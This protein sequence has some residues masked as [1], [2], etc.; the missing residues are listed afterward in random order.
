[1]SN[2]KLTFTKINSPD[3]VLAPEGVTLT[4]IDKPGTLRSAGDTG[5]SI[6]RG[7]ATGTK[8][9]ADAFGADNVVSRGASRIAD[10]LGGMR[11]DKSKF[12]DTV[13]TQR[14]GAAEASGSKWNEF[15]A[16]VRNFADRPIDMLAEGIGSSAPT[17]AAAALTGGVV[18]P[19]TATALRIAAGAGMGSV[20]GA[21]AVKGQ[22]YDDV[23]ARHIKAGLSEADAGARA[24]EAQSYSGENVDQIALGAGLGA[25]AGTTGAE[26]AV[27]RIIGHTGKTGIKPVIANMAAEGGTEFAQG[28]QERLAS[29]IAAQREGFDAPT[30][31]GVVGQGTVEGLAG[32][33][34]GAAFGVAEQMAGRP[35]VV[36]DP[37][38]GA[39]SKALSLHP[40]VEQPIEQPIAEPIDPAT[41]GQANYSKVVAQSAPMPLDK[42][43]SIAD[44][45]NADGTGV[46]TVAPH[47]SMGFT[48]VPSDWMTDEQLSS[49]ASIQGDGGRLEAPAEPDQAPIRVDA[50]GNAIQETP[51][52]AAEIAA[53]KQRYIDMGKPTP[54]GANPNDTIQKAAELSIAAGIQPQ[55]TEPGADNGRADQVPVPEVAAQSLESGGNQLPGSEFVAPDQP[56]GGMGSASGVTGIAVPSSGTDGLAGSLGLADT[57]IA[58]SSDIAG[59]KIDKKWTAFDPASGTLGINRAE[60]PQIKAE[61]RGAMVN[62][63]NARGIPHQQETVSAGDLKPTQAEF[64]PSKVKQAMGFEGGDRSILV[65][66]DNHV[67][68]GHHQWLA[69]REAGEPVK[70]IRLNA[71]IRELL[72]AAAEFPSSHT[73]AGATATGAVADNARA[74]NPVVV[75]ETPVDAPQTVIAR[76]GTTPNSAD[77]VTVRSGVVHIGEY[78]AQDFESGKDITVPEGSTFEQVADALRKGNVLSTKQRIYMG[79]KGM[80]QAKAKAPDKQETSDQD[81]PDNRPLVAEMDADTLRRELLTDALTGLGNRRAYDESAKLPVQAV[82]DADGLKWV[83]DNLGHD[84]GDKLLKAIGQALGDETQNAYH[85]SGDEFIVQAETEAEV[86]AIMDRAVA[87]MDGVRIDGTDTDGKDI[88]LTGVG[89]SYG[90]A[91]DLREAEKQLGQHKSERETQGQRAGRGEI[92]PNAAIGSARGEDQ[93]GDAAA[94][95]EQVAREQDDVAVKHAAIDA[96]LAENREALKG[97]KVG[98][99]VEFTQPGTYT[100]RDG[101]KR[102]GLVV[103]GKIE[104]IDDA[105]QGRVKVGNHS[106]GAQFLKK[107]DGVQPADTGRQDGWRGN[108]IKASKVMKD[109]GIERAD[110]MKLA[111]MLAAIDAHDSASSAKQKAP[112]KPRKPKVSPL[113]TKDPGEYGEAARRVFLQTIRKSGGVSIDDA[114]DI[115]GETVAN[116]YRLSPGFFA[117]GAPGIDLVARRLHEAGYITD[118]EY[119]DTDGGVQV[120]RDLINDALRKAPVLTS[121]QQERMAELEALEADAHAELQDQD[122]QDMLAEILGAE[123]TDAEFAGL[124]DGILPDDE[125]NQMDAARARQQEQDDEQSGRIEDQAGET[126]P[127]SAEARAQGG[128]GQPQ[129]A[130]GFDLAGQTPAELAAAD[131]Q[132]K[133]E[134]DKAERE[135]NQATGPNVTADQVDLF[136]TQEGLFNSN[137]D[138]AKEADK[139]IQAYTPP[140]STKEA[141]ARWE[142]G[143]ERGANQNALFAAVSKALDAGLFYNRD[144]DAFVAKEL[145]VTD[146]QRKVGADKVEGGAFG[147]DIYHARKAV[148]KARADKSNS[149]AGKRLGLKVGEN[150]GKLRLQDGK[151]ASAATVEAVSEKDVTLIAKRGPQTIRVTI[152]YTS[153]ETYAERAENSYLNDKQVTPAERLAQAGQVD[154]GLFAKPV[155]EPPVSM[156]REQPVEMN[157]PEAAPDRDSFTLDRLNRDTDQIESVTFERGEYVRYTLS[158]KDSFGEIDGISHARSEFSVDGLWYPFGFAYKA[159]K[160][161]AAEKPTV[162]LSSVIESA[163]KKYG[164]DLGYADRIH[165][166]AVQKDLFDRLYKGEA[167]ADEFK[168]AF[169]S[170]QNNKAG[171]TAELSAMTKDGLFKEFPGLAYRY[172]NDKKAD[173]VEA[174]YRGMVTQFVLGDSLTYGMGKNAMENAVRAIVDKTTDADLAKFADGIKQSIAERKARKEEAKAGMDNPETLEDF[175]RLLHARRE[176]MGGATFVELRMSLTPEQRAQYDIL[177]AEKSR[178][179]RG[180]KRD[181]ERTRVQAAD[182][183]TGAEIIATKHTRDGYDLFVVKAAERVERDVYNQWLSAAKKMGGWYSAFKGNGAIPGFQFKTREGAE[184]FQKY[185]SAGDTQAVQEQAKA[186]RNEFADDRSQTAVERLTEMADSLE[187][188]A[189]ASLGQ[190]RKANTDKRARQAASA[191][192]AANSDKAMAQTM[193]NI[194]GAIENGTAKMLD[195]VRQKVQVETL[196]GFVN[197]AQSDKLR[198][199]YPAYV[200]YERH[201]GE[202]PTADTADYVTFPNYTAFRSDLASLGR[203]LLDTEGTK[204]LG[205][206]LMKVADDVSDAYLKFAKENIDKVSRFRTKDGGL[207]AFPSKA[208]AEASIQ[209]SGYKGAA[210][211]LPVKRNENV[212]ILSPSEAIKRGVWTGDNDK[213][214]TLN[215]EFGAELVEKIGKASRRGEKVSVPWQFESAYDKRK[216]LAAMGIETPAE[217]RAAVREFI[218]LRETPKEADKIKEMERAMIGRRNDGMDFFPTPASVADEMVE[219]AD[220]QPGMSVLEPSAGMGHIAERIRA[221]GVDPDVVELSNERNEL[222][223]A[224]GFRVVG[225]DFMD[226]NPREFFTFGDTFRDKDGTEGVMRGLGGMGSN[227]VRLVVNGDERTARYV[228]RDSL[229]PVSKNGSDSGYDRILMNPPFGDRRDA[230]HVQHAYELLKPGGRIVAIMGEGVFFGSDK[231]AQA[232]RDWLEQ[233]GA[234]DEKLNE[235]T[236]LDPGLPVNTGTNAR[237][238]VIDKPGSEIV[239]VAEPDNNDT[240]F[241]RTVATT[242]DYDKRIDAL[243]SGKPANRVGAVV[244]DRSDMLDM[245]GMGNK[246]VR[247]VESKV[248][249]SS[250]NHG[251]TA[252]HWKKIPE[253]LDSPAA[254]FDSDTAPGRLV[255]IAPERVNGAPVRMIIEPDVNMDG[256]SIN[257]MVNAYDAH[258]R[259]P[260]RHW[261]ESGLTRYIDKAKSRQLLESSGLQLPG[262]M[263][264]MSQEANGSKRKI[265]TDRDLVKYRSEQGAAFSRTDGLTDAEAIKRV[266]RVQGVVNGIKANWKNAPEIIVVADMQDARVP[267]RVR[268][269]DAEM[270]SNGASGEPRGFI[271]GG[272]VYIVAGQHK[273]VADVVTTVAHETLGHAG[274]R[275]LYG[276]ALNP[277]LRQ[278]VNMRRAEVNAKVKEYGFDPESERDLMRAAEEVLANMAQTQPELGFVKRAIAAI[279]QWLRERGYVKTLSDN[280]IISN[281]I[282]P[283]R[284]YIERGGKPSSGIESLQAAYHRVFHGTPH[285]FKPE[286]GFPHGRFHLDYI[287]TGEGAQ[288]YG[289][290]IYFAESHG[291]AG[292]YRDMARR[293]YINYAG[294][295]RVKHAAGQLASGISEEDTRDGLQILGVDEQKHD[296]IIKEARALLA[297][298]GQLYNLDIPNSVLPNLLDWDKPLSEQ[299]A[300]VRAA[301]SQI[302]E[303]FLL[304]DDDRGVSIYKV[305]TD[306]LDT[307]QGRDTDD[308]RG[309]KVASE[310][311]AS[312]GIVG[313]R[314]L[315]GNS[316]NKALK[317]IKREFLAELPEDAEIGEV[318]DMI[319]TGVFSAKNEALLSAMKADDWLGF[320]YPSQAVSAA[321]SNDLQ[322]YDASPALLQ[323]VSSA[324]EGGTYNFVIW[325]QPTLDKV[326]MLERNGEKLDAIRAADAAFS[327]TN[328]TE[329]AAQDPDIMFSRT[330]ELHAAV[331]QRAADLLTTQ[332]TFNNWWHKSVGTQYHKAHIDADFRKA[333]NAVQSYLSGMSAFANSS[334]DLAD[335]LIP[336]LNSIRDLWNAKQP[337]Q[338]DIKAIS[339]PIFTGTLADEKVYGADELRDRFKLTPNQIDLYVQF[340]ASV[341][342]SLDDLGKTDILRY[343]GA[344]VA[345]MR[346]DVLDAPT[347]SRAALIV[348]KRLQE[349]GKEDEAKVVVDKGVRVADL[350][351]KGYAP[352]TRFGRYTL[353]VTEGDEQ[354]YFS[355]FESEA[356]ANAM[357]RQM[358][359]G[360]P[361]A[362]VTQ[363][364]LSAE[365]YKLFN[366]I[367]PDTLEL[368]AGAMGVENN[369]LVQDYIKL[370]KSNRSAMKRL[371]KR[372]GIAGFSEDVPRILA[373]FIT[374]NARQAASNVYGSQM[375]KAAE[376]IPKEKGDVK[377]E[378]I[379]MIDFAR[380]PTEDAAKM[381]GMLFVQ[382]IGGSVASAMVNL[383]QP[384]TMSYPYLHQFSKSAG[385]ELAKAMKLATVGGTLD[386][387]LKQALKRAEMDGVVSPQEIHQLQAE[388]VK[389]GAGVGALARMFGVKGGT[390]NKLDDLSK[391][392]LFAW[393]SLFSLAEQFNRRSTFIAAYNIAR[394]NKQAD[395]FAFAEK[396]VVETQGIYNRGNR[397]DW[398]RGA[399][400]ALIFTFKQYSISYMEFLKRLPPK[401]RAIA[402]AILV[403]AAGLQ[404]IPFADDLDDLIDTLAQQMGYAWNTKAEKEKFA[405]SILGQTGADF[406]L[407]GTSALPGFPLDFSARLGMSNL[408]PGTGMLLKNK[409]DK[410][411]EVLDVFGVAG[412]VVKDALRGDVLPIAVRNMLKAADMANTGM[413]R[414]YSGKKVIDT[415]GLDAATKLIGFHPANVAREGRAARMD[416]QDVQLAR[417]I[418]SEI[419]G[420]MAQGIFTGDKKA[421]TKAREKLA[422]WNAKNPDKPIVITSQQI[423]ARVK[424]MA[425]T[426]R[427]RLIKSAPKELR[428]GLVE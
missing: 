79:A 19:A 188:K 420:N 203:A 108:A 5:L 97:F 299:T 390:A 145:G 252:E 225:R 229:T 413:Y 323:A 371:I 141:S 354:L 184:A 161:S 269:M 293:D 349:L 21:G 154:D 313:N 89:V 66:S 167:S 363:G 223:E 378:A 405:A 134:A 64:S 220:I 326:A 311:L 416:M 30:W 59:D 174:A 67:L 279:R 422:D 415:N 227:R 370:A 408:L 290:G 55:I 194:A 84:S 175:N 209:H 15:K 294:P 18:N 236:F 381:R 204:K 224:K 160:P 49:F 425:Q 270:K 65:S 327:R 350:K 142:Y 116:S 88:V 60:M 50:Q 329:S 130:E 80:R 6:A 62:F 369:E 392:G 164:A 215:A 243:F 231:K 137:R 320:E 386:P 1:M 317:D 200:D 306:A 251:L 232:F 341:D 136:N 285:L 78:P 359:E 316:R 74:T 197:T 42:A 242:T 90:I 394:Q 346:A 39:I 423:M 217:L 256:L 360:N 72:T 129:R 24:Q 192:R 267:E 162:P 202:N 389:K 365:S 179:E 417:N 171:I 165:T 298:S 75:N 280:D 211:V 20:Q 118:A 309:P 258:G 276:E 110:G 106:V 163:N 221:A 218:N 376:A 146:E 144:V 340:R 375:D 61:H 104:R 245:L 149:D 8:M 296:A 148:E 246:P 131:K 385:V 319:G 291:V 268:D 352:L 189:D 121:E 41:T 262:V 56:A 238:V 406:A 126:Q 48:V 38:A 187:G 123:L 57:A 271:S 412:G 247:V 111:D 195:R 93:P 213:R 401:E 34:S 158:G 330:V 91:G 23:K 169:D 418:E 300:E 255:F 98:D 100:Q 399:P 159:E 33:G 143:T 353:H 356:E 3:D 421:V 241:S 92:P 314:Y 404:G 303:R 362:T 157:K 168:A 222:L 400:G 253:W 68:D 343:A 358:K 334:A 233:K 147:Y 58:A 396:A 120:A 183:T 301:L 51:E 152:P 112:R 205:Q 52:Q 325:D 249:A 156:E 85:V 11:S 151:I 342:K 332:K 284:A 12:L 338:A 368:F 128:E 7:V 127:G 212:I 176:E 76:V 185:V 170:L 35:G 153:I 132:A 81:R 398:A 25:V 374:S 277:I 43:Q 257:L 321:L 77:P 45:M 181:D 96:Q 411:G 190:E 150:I 228:D 186:R 297:N 4:K 367:S 198:A 102:E 119:N 114:A 403:L 397:P 384:L 409:T 305:I 117:A 388:A 380:N 226:I 107:V 10:G 36:V 275:G 240:A 348:A 22:I 244:L 83:N 101:T 250:T 426:R 14:M 366:G 125:L 133:A 31:Q 286:P 357:A 13:S 139:A 166:L 274:L 87:R 54:R 219:T 273:S 295:D 402:L 27:S 210:I 70:V 135:A 283:A 373:S 328:Q 46:Y 261:V 109:F 140:T 407:H 292:S 414:D 260:V 331:S 393:G 199:L 379:K 201:Q 377:D 196:Y 103:R 86:Q 427:E 17:L 73:A 99:E 115:T 94:E 37:N 347:A 9:V 391:R 312:I 333:F 71:P 337:S 230:A 69:K 278:I 410:M 302:K 82:V 382:Y 344:D 424:K 395:P 173:I 214:I 182:A 193:R 336:Q 355:L 172:K 95:T 16:G 282:L 138:S 53:L 345:D 339:G 318:E 208:M 265:Y 254:V 207:A 29:N 272:K 2:E 178:G 324:K 266:V 310:Y 308:S 307:K 122:E 191:E 287:G 235:G 40:D 248:I 419:A 361:G 47:G 26:G 289:F 28:G 387:E 364:V 180:T 428:G 322:G 259:N 351:A 105:E 237:M 315:D 63:L 383:T 32:A 234:T 372:K 263:Q 288:A 281:F 124:H 264:S 44:A 239:A 216:R 113:A 177:T 206:R 304:R 335:R 155:Q